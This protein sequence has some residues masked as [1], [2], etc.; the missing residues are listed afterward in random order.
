MT[1]QGPYIRKKGK[2]ENRKNGKKRKNG[3]SEKIGKSGK[4]GKIRSPS[5]V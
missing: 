4:I 2:M 5:R 1:S 3:K